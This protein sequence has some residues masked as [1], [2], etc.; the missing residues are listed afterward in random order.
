MPT[1]RILLLLLLLSGP[2]E[3]QKNPA[4][5]VTAILNN[6]RKKI[7]KALQS[8]PKYMCTETVDRYTYEAATTRKS[9]SC[10]E[11]E[12]RG[13]SKIDRQRGTHDRLR[14][15]VAVSGDNEMYSWAG[16]EH[17]SDRSLH[18]LVQTGATSTGTF[19][20]FLS[21]IFGTAAAT[22]TYNGDV[23]RSGHM[24]AEFG[25]A[26]PVE[27]SNYSIGNAFGHSI[28]G[29]RG[30]FWV[31]PD[32]FDLVRLSITADHLPSALNACEANTTLD[33]DHIQLNH[34]D[35]VIPQDVHWNVVNLDGSELTSR[36]VFSGCHEFRGESTLH[37][38]AEPDAGQAAASKR[39]IVVPPDAAFSLLLLDPISTATAAAGDSFRA[40]LAAAIRTKDAG[41]SIPKGAIVTGRIVRIER[42]YG[43]GAQTLTLGLKTETI[44]ANGMLQP[45]HAQLGTA[46][47]RHKKVAV[48]AAGPQSLGTFD[49]I[50][51]SDVGVGFLYFENASDRYVIRAGLRIKG[52]TAP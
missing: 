3:A 48:G 34:A 22:F 47:T 21:S 28:V 8:L 9:L 10:A 43:P 1:M 39:A 49:E 19:A 14:L 40:Q 51:D 37:F 26:V 5:D 23:E 33:Y 18:A 32:T 42:H 46:I 2:L 4:G 17:F 36:T 50:Q 44:Q 6:T 30:M 7:V 13:A 38:E 24:V 27:K 52:T 16:E 45:F 29:Y 31:D 25:F 12:K 35:F 11:L 15:D 20:T 41:I